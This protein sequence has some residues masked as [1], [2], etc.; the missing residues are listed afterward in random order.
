MVEIS[1]I[2]RLTLLEMLRHPISG[3]PPWWARYGF[4]ADQRQL[5]PQ[6][7]LTNVPGVVPLESGQNFGLGW[8]RHNRMTALGE[9]TAPPMQL[10]QPF[11]AGR[12]QTMLNKL[13][14]KSSRT[15]SIAT[16]PTEAPPIPASNGKSTPVLVTGP[17]GDFTTTYK[18]W[19]G[20][21]KQTE[22]EG[23]NAPSSSAN[24]ATEQDYSAPQKS[25]SRLEAMI[26]TRVHQACG[27]KE[28]DIGNLL[29]TWLHEQRRAMTHL[30]TVLDRVGKQLRDYLKTHDDLEL[31]TDLFGGTICQTTGTMK[32][33]P[34]TINAPLPRNQTR[35]RL[36]EPHAQTTSRANHDPR[37]SPEIGVLTNHERAS[38]GTRYQQ[39]HGVRTHRGAHQEGRTDPG[40]E[41]GTLFVDS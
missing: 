20:R 26:P 32:P 34:P 17:G 31:A 11:K 38:R 2:L 33:D 12:A 7:R 27:Q 19:G 28:P 4:Q 35:E 40:A 5:S 9:L 6:G 18:A 13:T 10:F 15:S 24:H 16:T 1:Q 39:S 8:A 36:H 14:R 22:L 3:G 41:Q 25:E 21:L 37:V 29:T 23:T 30:D